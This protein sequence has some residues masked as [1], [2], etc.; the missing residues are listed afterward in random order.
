MYFAESACMFGS[1]NKNLHVLKHRLRHTSVNATSPTELSPTPRNGMLA[2]AAKRLDVA[3]LHEI[4]RAALTRR[5]DRKFLLPAN[6]TV[7][8]IEAMG[9]DYRVVLARDERFALYDTV[10][11]DTPS[12]RSYHDHRR[13]RRPR[14][15]LRI[16]NYVDRDLS[17][18]EYKE[19]TARGDTRKLRWKRPEASTV[20]TDADIALLREAVPELFSEGA[21]VSQARTVF[22]R[23]MLLN[24]HTIERATLDFNLVLE[25]GSERCALHSLVVAEIKDSGRG[26]TSPLVAALRKHDARALPFSKYCIAI[27]KLGHERANAFL[28]SLRAIE[29]SL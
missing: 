1:Q 3:H 7:N 4:E 21:L 17:M 23:L 2:A 11:F 25:R 22:Y 29:G 15:K 14:F 16:R 28:P 9:S 18:L 8:V 20:L 10:Y 12:L 5:F 26:A 19:K 13:G 6:H 27:A 24:T